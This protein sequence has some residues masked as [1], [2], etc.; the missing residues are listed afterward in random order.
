MHNL[1]LNNIQNIY[2]ACD[3]AGLEMKIEIKKYLEGEFKNENRGSNFE[4]IDMGSHVYNELDDYTDYIHKAG[5]ALADDIENDILSVA[6]VF[7][8][9]GEG[10]AIVMNRYKGV[11]CTTYYGGNLDIIKLGR[12]HNN[13]N[14]ISF[15]A[16]FLDIDESKKSIEIFLSTDFAGGKHAKRVENIEK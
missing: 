8:G 16:R 9:S 10:E 14:S 7:G 5:G 2:L 1:N 4:I 3:H 6:F 15:G 13:A 12:E 11:R